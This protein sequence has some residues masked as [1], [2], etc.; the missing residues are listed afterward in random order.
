MLEVEVKFPVSDLALVEK[1]LKERVS[2]VP[3]ER[4]ETDTYFNAPDRDFAV[5][6][7]ALRL[8]RVGQ[9]NFVT[10]KGPKKEQTTK[11]R[12]EI[13][14][15]LAEGEP[16]ADH[17][18]QLLVSLGYRPVA[19]VKK[20]RRIFNL[21]SD[22]FQ[23]AVCLDQVE[24]VGAFVEIEILAPETSFDQARA[25]VLRLAEA[26]ALK[27]QERRSYLELLLARRGGE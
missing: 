6:D 1:R 14:V 11:T 3:V 7:E 27:T 26:L 8:R 21:E 12:L 24:E 18:K 22:N 9:A 5:T 2:A 17:F 20:R 13:E 19:D 15:P 10:Y 4:L 16:V 23:M 25:A